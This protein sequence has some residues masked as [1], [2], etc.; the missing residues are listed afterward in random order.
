M[1]I[2]T[3]TYFLI[4]LSGFGLIYGFR[5]GKISLILISDFEYLAFSMFWGVFIYAIF[6]WIYRDD[7]QKFKDLIN[8][9]VYAVGFVMTLFSLTLG[10]IIGR[11][12]FRKNKI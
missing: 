4:I 6:E 11:C 1:D 2:Q 5:K 8:S 7:Y 10:Y 3:Y 12:F 9:N